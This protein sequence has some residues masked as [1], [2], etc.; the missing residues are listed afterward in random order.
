MHIEEAGDDVKTITIVEAPDALREYITK[1]KFS[2]T[3]PHFA[4]VSLR[5][6]IAQ[7]LWKTT[8]KPIMRNSSCAYGG[9]TLYI[10]K[11]FPQFPT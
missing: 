5:L 9:A 7:S 8:R 11:T 1:C 2:S 6:S 10:R 4:L 3:M